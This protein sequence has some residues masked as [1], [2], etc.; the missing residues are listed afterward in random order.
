[1][2]KL[3]YLIS[4]LALLVSGCTQEEIVKHVAFVSGVDSN[5]NVYHDNN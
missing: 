4:L 1:M 2:K 3:V 5:R